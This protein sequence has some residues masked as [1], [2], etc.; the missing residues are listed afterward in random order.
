MMETTTVTTVPRGLREGQAAQFASLRAE[1]GA[2][3]RAA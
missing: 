2:S 1:R 3:S